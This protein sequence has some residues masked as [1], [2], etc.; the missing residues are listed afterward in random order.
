MFKHGSS[1]Q[2]ASLLERYQ[3]CMILHG[4]GDA[5]GYKNG[6]WEFNFSSEEIHKELEKLGGVESLHIDKSFAMPFFFFCFSS[7]FFH[8]C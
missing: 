4:V 2:T 6:E 1:D 8:P 7:L 5:M 3:A